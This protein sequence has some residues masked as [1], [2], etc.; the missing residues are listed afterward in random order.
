[1]SIKDLTGLQ[2]IERIGR[3]IAPLRDL[4]SKEQTKENDVSLHP[5]GKW[6]SFD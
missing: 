5:H 6:Q 1:M 3:H 2:S 4:I